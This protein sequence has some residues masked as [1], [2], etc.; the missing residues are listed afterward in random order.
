MTYGLV[1]TVGQWINWFEQKQDVLTSPPLTTAGGTLLGRLN[2]F[3]SST[4]QA[5][6]NL[7]VGVTPTSPTNGDMWATSSGLFAQINSSTINLGLINS[8]TGN[9]TKAVTGGAGSYVGCMQFDGSGNATGT[10]SNCGTAGA[11]AP[12][13]STTQVQYNCTGAF[14]GSANF[15]WT[16]GSNTLTV[17]NGGTWAPAGLTLAPTAGTGTMGWGAAGFSLDS[18]GIVD[19]GN[20]TAKDK[21]CELRLATLTSNTKINLP[22]NGALNP[23]GTIDTL[24]NGFFLRSSGSGQA[25]PST[26]FNG[27]GAMWV[28]E[29]LGGLTFRGQPGTKSPVCYGG[30]GGS[31]NCANWGLNFLDEYG[32]QVW[33]QQ[34][35]ANNNQ[36][37]MIG[38]LRASYKAGLDESGFTSGM[39]QIFFSDVV[40]AGGIGGPGTGFSITGGSGYT[41]GTYTGVPLATPGAGLY[42]GQVFATVVISGGAVTAVTILPPDQFG[43]AQL[44]GYGVGLHVG[45]TLSTANVNIGGTGSGFSITVTSLVNGLSAP[46]L[47]GNFAGSPIIWGLGPNTSDPNDGLTVRLGATEN[48][49]TAWYNSDKL[50]LAL[51]GALMLGTGSGTAHYPTPPDG[52]LICGSAIVNN[53]GTTAFTVCN[54]VASF[55]AIGSGSAGGSGYTNGAYTGVAMTP[56]WGLTTTCSNVTANIT[57][58]GGAVTVFTLNAPGTGCFVGDRLIP[59]AAIGAGSGAYA[60]VATL[61]TTPAPISVSLIGLLPVTWADNQ[62][63][64]AGQV[65][66]DANFIYVCT[67][68]NTVK[69]A[70]LSTF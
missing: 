29:P 55:S 23:A 69:R 47:I 36:D 67:S 3:P 62:T 25:A 9:T 49:G 37:L 44:V 14:C 40:V 57:V 56:D 33:G 66:V 46:Q 41:T 26:F 8:L 68:T 18:S 45:D 6:V 20:G 43:N 70:A 50:S 39:A 21:T 51:G 31:L 59:G 48:S 64:V 42:T 53:S 28:S 61:A 15:F 35:A 60:T 17:A 2:L 11:T 58:S 1:P 13:G 7:G 38:L 24:F 12:G 65:T 54:P 52:N 5:G 27:S 32:W 34:T 22:D 16:N 30:A 10:G 4:I 63:C 19:C